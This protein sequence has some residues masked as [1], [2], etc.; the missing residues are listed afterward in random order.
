M[1]HPV[2]SQVPIPFIVRDA[3]GA[4]TTY[5]TAEITI[6]QPDGTLIVLTDGDGITATTTGAGVGIFTPTQ[7]GRHATWGHTTGPS[8]VIAP[9]AFSVVALSSSSAPLVGVAEARGWLNITTPEWD[10]L[11]LRALA[12]ATGITEGW[13]GLTLRRTVVTETHTGG[14]DS[15]RLERLPIQTITAVTEDGTVLTGGAGIDWVLRPGGILLRGTGSSTG[16]WTDGADTVTVTYVAGYRVIPDRLLAAVSELTRHIFTALQRGGGRDD[17]YTPDE[18]VRAL[19]A[20]L[21]GPRSGSF[22]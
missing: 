6:E 9:D 15:V 13:T 21:L 17:E 14:D 8:T 11:I 2:G 3:T 22:A 1:T 7:A 18:Q 10:S 5:T 19:C 12:A 4:P 16:V 20:M